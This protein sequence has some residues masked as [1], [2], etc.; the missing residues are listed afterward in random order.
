[1]GKEPA[2][3]LADFSEGLI[4]K[5]QIRK[6][7]KVQLVLGD[8]TLDVSEGAAFSFLQVLSICASLSLTHSQKP[9]TYQETSKMLFLSGKFDKKGRIICLLSDCNIR[10]LIFFD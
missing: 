1:M 4:G 7:G 2:P 3:V 10:L 5:L 9:Q 6:S 8:V